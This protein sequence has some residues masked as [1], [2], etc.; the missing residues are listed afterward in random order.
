MAAGAI[1]AGVAA[2]MQTATTS[3]STW[4]TGTLIV[5]IFD[6]QSKQLLFRGQGQA[7]ISDKSSKNTSNL[8]KALAKMFKDF[9]PTASK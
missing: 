1:V 2:A 4:N 5:D 3:T 7:T 9:P 6:V 8:Y